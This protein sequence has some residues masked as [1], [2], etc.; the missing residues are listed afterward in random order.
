MRASVSIKVC[1]SLFKLET[2]LFL[3]S[4][5]SY[6]ERLPSTAVEVLGQVFDTCPLKKV[7]PL[8]S[9]SLATHWSFYIFFFWLFS[10]LVAGFDVGSNK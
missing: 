10:I 4:S 9:L 5:S 7:D 1:F 8:V 2:Y 3:L 6:P